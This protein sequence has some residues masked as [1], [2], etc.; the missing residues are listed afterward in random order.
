MKALTLTQPWAQLIAWREKMIET[1]GW[2]T[3]YR[4][5]LVIYAAKGFPKWV[6]ETCEE[7]PFA[8]ALGGMKAAEL[9]V[10]VGVCV[11]RV[12]GCIRTTDMHKAEAVL[13]YKPSAKELEFGDYSEG[14]YA[15]LLEYVRPLDSVGP[16]KG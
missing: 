9:P 16:V 14:R 2:Y 1:R 5:E 15:W 12:L 13:G 10:S 3:A 4:G 6:K 8:Q 7:E 11:V